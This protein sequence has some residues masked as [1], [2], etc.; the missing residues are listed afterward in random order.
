MKRKPIYRAPERHPWTS[1]DTQ[2]NI[3]SSADW[4]GAHPALCYEIN[5][6]QHEEL[7]DSAIVEQI[8]RQ[9]R[10]AVGFWQRDSVIRVEV[11]HT[12][13][14]SVALGRVTIPRPKGDW[15]TV[16]YFTVH[17][18]GT[19]FLTMHENLDPRPIVQDIRGLLVLPLGHPHLPEQNLL[20]GH[21]PIERIVVEFPEFTEQRV[22]PL[23]TS[24]ATLAIMSSQE[25]VELTRPG[26]PTDRV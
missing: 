15:C 13:Q 23:D 22:L 8:I 9:R 6:P 5:D 2:H 10:F 14:R 7:I 26:M 4:G 16:Q 17:P 11:N 1:V 20:V 12:P 21:D 19:S 25:L 18:V 24:M 3:I